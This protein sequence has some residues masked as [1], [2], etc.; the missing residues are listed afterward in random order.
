[1][2][3]RIYFCAILITLFFSAIL[4]ATAV[5]A[6]FNDQPSVGMGNYIVSQADNT[7]TLNNEKGLRLAAEYEIFNSEFHPSDAG[8]RKS[9]VMGADITLTSD[10]T[11]TADCHF[12]LGGYTLN[13]NG[14]NLIFSH[15]FAGDLLFTNGIL[16]N[17]SEGNLI[18]DTPYAAP[19]ID[20]VCAIEP[21]VREFDEQSA[22][23]AALD[24]AKEKITRGDAGCNYHSDIDFIRNYRGYGFN[25]QYIVP[26]ESSNLIDAAGKVNAPQVLT[27]VSIAVRVSSE[28]GNFKEGVVS[29]NLVDISNKTAWSKIAAELF[30][31]Y[32]S[33]Y[34]ATRTVSGEQI[35]YYAVRTGV[36]LPNG[37][38]Y[39]GSDFS[40]SYEVSVNG[41]ALENSINY[42]NGMPVLYCDDMSEQ[43]L[44][45]WV[46]P[47]FGG[48][49]AQSG[50]VWTGI[51]NLSSYAALDEDTTRIINIMF[52]DGVE[53]WN[54]GDG[55]YSTVALPENSTVVALGV[56]SVQYS[57]SDAEGIYEI[58]QGVLRVKQGK[59][60]TEVTE[61]YLNIKFTFG[62]TVVEKSVKIN[63]RELGSDF[64]PYFTYF[65]RV[66]A[67]RTDYYNT[68]LTFRMPCSYDTKRP[69][70]GYKLYLA[71]S[72]VEYSGEDIKLY[73]CYDGGESE[74][75]I[76]GVNGENFK[77]IISVMRQ[78]TSYFEIRINPE[79]WTSTDDRNFELEYWYT[80]TRSTDT[81]FSVYEKARSTFKLMGF[82]YK[83]KVNGQVHFTQEIQKQFHDVYCSS[84][85]RDVNGAITQLCDKS[86]YL[87]T[88]DLQR[89]NSNEFALVLTSSSDV[90]NYTVLQYLLNTSALRLSS[91]QGAFTDEDLNHLTGLVNLKKL[92]LDNNS[93]TAIDLL[94]SLSSLE[95]LDVSNN[96]I[97]YFSCIP[98]FP[99]GMSAYIYNNT[100]KGSGIIAWLNRFL[101][102]STG[103]LNLRYYIEAQ[104]K[105]IKVYNENANEQF[106]M[107]ADM[108][109]MYYSSAQLCYQ[110][111]VESSMVVTEGKCDLSPI[112][113]KLDVSQFD[114]SF[115]NAAAVPDGLFQ[116][117]YT[118]NVYFKNVESSIDATTGKG[119]AVFSIVWMKEAETS[120]L[121]LGPW[122]RDTDKD[123]TF[124]TYTYAVT[125]I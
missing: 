95:I 34:E 63:Y 118:G 25:Y 82:F 29:V 33:Y 73:F 59:T 109:Y 83:G 86:D 99:E 44:R 65:D 88:S 81:T 106:G 64:T 43:E 8:K 62:K 57:L 114:P 53:I 36:M 40:Y 46:T 76:R 91:Q 4:A 87:F 116:V 107:N 120:F 26:P 97:T 28:S 79:L 84:C 111:T 12:D 21:V 38:D 121:G 122:T 117:K 51:L 108:S 17:T 66:L 60:P 56:D 6:Y 96:D 93:L 112:Y 67:E 110:H 42:I 70:L 72:S 37:N 18:Y 48:E 71:G 123:I 35:V 113:D 85:T 47:L 105:N 77:D 5:Y 15:T 102:G 90:S 16:I 14:Y 2:K 89:R 45:L 11:I 3:K 125:I 69:F 27:N 104:S 13:L 68:Y 115:L 49:P 30:S 98:D 101:Y 50:T 61:A 55:V 10:L 94:T 19:A 23:L 1:M 20:A 22:L 119:A 58:S 92:Y 39:I 100:P 9:L 31:D 75:D 80:F 103:P 7:I 74:M 54:E 32:F 78:R 24:F 52:P 124:F 41:V